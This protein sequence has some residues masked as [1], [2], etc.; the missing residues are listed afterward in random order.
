MWKLS[1][2]HCSDWLLNKFQF[3]G[4]KHKKIRHLLFVFTYVQ[5]P[6]HSFKAE[7][8]HSRKRM[9]F[10]SEIRLR[11]VKYGFAMWNSFAVKYLLR[12]C[13]GRIS[14]HIATKEQYFT[15]SK[16]NYFTFGRCRIFHL[17]NLPC[18]DII[19]A[20]SRC[21]YGRFKASWPIH[22]FCG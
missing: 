7:K 15:I 20:E 19:T 10:F 16:G 12:K 4:Q 6:F 8:S 11:R 2:S 3:V 5:T 14:F 17:K 21:Y 18:Y 13:D 1:Q 22:R 9:A